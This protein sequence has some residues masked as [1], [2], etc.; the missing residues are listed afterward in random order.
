[1]ATDGFGASVPSDDASANQDAYLVHDG[2]GLY[3]VCDGASD[4]PAGEVASKTAVASIEAFLQD[5]ERNRPVSRLRPFGADGLASRAVR[6][7]M[8]AVIAAAAG[9][10]DLE[11]MATTVT[12]LLVRGHR[13]TICHVGDSRV[14]LLRDGFLHQL[15]SDY[16]LAAAEHPE[17]DDAYAEASVECFALG[18]VPGDT[19]YLCSDGAEDAVEDPGIRAS[20]HGLPPYEQALRVISGAK[21]LNPD[22]DATVVV[23]AV[24][25]EHEPGWLWVSELPRRFAYGHV[26]PA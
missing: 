14:Y 24:R 10:E 5:Q 17:T 20:C 26:L 2:L 13:A 11:G 4:G 1:M 7:A 15:T 9:D 22:R 23:V 25:G 16:E 19:F 21:T 12:M 18:L 8:R 3:V 6:D